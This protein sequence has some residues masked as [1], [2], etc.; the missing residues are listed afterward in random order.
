MTGEKIIDIARRLS[1]VTKTKLSD[2]DALLYLNIGIKE[3]SSLVHG[4]YTE[5]S[6]SVVSGDEES[7]LP[8]D[9][10]EIMYVLWNDDL[11]QK[12]SW[13]GMYDRDSGTPT[14][15]A[16]VG[17][18]LRLN[19]IPSANGT[20]NIFYYGIPVDLTA[21]SETPGIPV[22]H[23]FA[24][25]DYVASKMSEEMF[26][27]ER[28]NRYYNQF[29]LLVRNAHAELANRNPEIGY[30]VPRAYPYVTGDVG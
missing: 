19:P 1:R 15:Y 26:D 23:H 11:L 22:E 28:A 8:A 6:V 13:E 18:R 17:R 27:S 21:V 20:V 7:D 3:F 25:A 4:I 14:K 5:A 9:F 2:S 16:I 30:R 29:K 10:T 12:G 24:L